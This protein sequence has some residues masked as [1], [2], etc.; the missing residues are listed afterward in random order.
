MF[1][2]YKR[3][4][5]GF[6]IATFIAGAFF[7]CRYILKQERELGY[8]QAVAE[9]K[10]KAFVA[11]TA[12]RN[13]ETQLLKQIQ[14]AQN[15]TVIREQEIKRLS[16]ALAVSDHQLRNTTTAIRNTL[17]SISCDAARRTAATALTVFEGCE[18]KYTEMAENATGHASDV[19]TLMDAWPK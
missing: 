5:I 8:N 2:T 1:G 12:A 15:A 16:T 6:L 7:A 13:K 17:P 19:I 14:E 9:F 10:A 11:E 3:F 4:L 18:G